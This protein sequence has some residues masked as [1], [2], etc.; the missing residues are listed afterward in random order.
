MG[1]SSR[2]GSIWATTWL[3]GSALS[4]T[5]LASAAILAG[6]GSPAPSIE[7]DGS[8]PKVHPTFLYNGNGSCTGASCH[9]GEAKKQ[10]GQMIGDENSIFDEKDPHAKAFKSLGNAQSKKIAATLKIDDA[11]KSDRCI[12]CHA[13][14]APEKQRG[15]KFKDFATNAVGCESCHGPSEKWLEAH[16]KAGWADE[17]R[18]NG[19][20]ATFEKFG[21]HDTRDLAVRGGMCVTCHLQI[22]KDM[23][24]AGHPALKFELYSYSNYQFK[25]K[26]QIH[27]TEQTEAGHAA[28][29]WAVGQAVA[30]A[31]AD[32]QAAHWKAKGWET[33]D[34]DAL[35]KVF[36]AG[37]EVAAASFGAGD[38]NGL[39]KAAYPKDKVIA[40]VNAYLAK[41]DAFKA[42]ADNKLNRDIIA[43]GIEALVTGTSDKELPDA[44]LD[45]AEKAHKVEGDDW[46]AALKAMAGFAK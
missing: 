37:K 26:F 6:A 1:S 43:S 12:S 19:S 14:P 5:L 13:M 21:L 7:A 15:P 29:M 25:E 27:W 45:A 46:T 10:S 24:D 41:A 44:F 4:A 34:A 33:K 36:A 30:S 9:S 32:A 8:G 18:K 39:N 16:A 22:D 20:T 42:G 40:A 35:S 31:A 23:V 3:A 28:K 38:A 2:N 17:Q 11:T